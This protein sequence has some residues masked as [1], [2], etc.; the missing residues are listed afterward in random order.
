MQTFFQPK[1][2]I[3]NSYDPWCNPLTFGPRSAN[4]QKAFRSHHIFKQLV[5]HLGRP[6][7]PHLFTHGGYKR[8]QL[9]F[10]ARHSSA[11]S[12]ALP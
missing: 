2:S 7:H 12:V 10:T 3:A 5:F 6:R 1:I 8:S 4:L 11:R 9:L